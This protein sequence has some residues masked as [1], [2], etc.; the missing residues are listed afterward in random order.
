MPEPLTRS[1]PSRTGH[2]R[3]SRIKKLQRRDGQYL[4]A[5][6]VSVLALTTGSL[7]SLA[8]GNPRA[9]PGKYTARMAQSGDTVE[10]KQ[11]HAQNLHKTLIEGWRKLSGVAQATQADW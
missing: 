2:R 5:H 11:V 9:C 3:I 1:A 10:G 8:V 7:A 4:V 6:L